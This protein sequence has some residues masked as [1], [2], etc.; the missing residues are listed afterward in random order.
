MTV[1]FIGLLHITGFKAVTR[2]PI[3]PGIR[4]V[5]M[6]NENKCC[7]AEV[8]SFPIQYTY[9]LSGHN[10]NEKKSCMCLGITIDNTMSCMVI[11]YI[12]TVNK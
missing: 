8:Y 1:L 11:T 6:E 9:T 5:R 2:R 4:Y 10:L 12:Y 3:R 7:C